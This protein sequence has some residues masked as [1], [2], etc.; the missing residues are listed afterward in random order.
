MSGPVVVDIPHQL[1]K[2]AARAR[3]DAGIGKLA[4]FV[5]GGTVSEHRWEGDT[6]VVA[7][8]AFGQRVS[9]RME[10]FDSHVHAV[11]ELPPLLQPFADKIRGKLAKDGAGLLK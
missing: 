3:M 5:P 7:V 11:F 1:G 10:V 2:A 6:M 4:G 8:S 9:S